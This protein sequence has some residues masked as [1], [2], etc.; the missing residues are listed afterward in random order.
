MCILKLSI[1]YPTKQPKAK[2]NSYANPQTPSSPIFYCDSQLVLV[3]WR[4]KSY[5]ERDDAQNNE[6]GRDEHN[7]NGVLRWRR[8]SRWWKN[9]KHTSYVA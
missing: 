8:F 7:E 3:G 9:P 4:P 6:D 1:P 5:H 2:R